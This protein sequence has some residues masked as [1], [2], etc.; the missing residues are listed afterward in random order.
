VAVAVLIAAAVVGTSFPA[1]AL[2]R[3]HHQVSAADAQLARV[4]QQNALL[5]E[6]ER[7]LNDKTEIQRLARQDYQLV[8]PGESLFNVLPAAGQSVTTPQGT[9][10]LGDPA[11]QPLVSPAD[12]PDMTPDPGNPAGGSGGSSGSSG[13]SGSVS[14]SVSGTS[15]PTTVAPQGSGGGFW[16]RVTSTLEFWR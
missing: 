1:S 9:T 3:E 15:T 6:Q 10:S 14:G 13:S 11:N 2:L 12:A 8:L 7:Q 16:H 4:D 5:A